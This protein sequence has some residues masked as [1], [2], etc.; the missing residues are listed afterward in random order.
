MLRDMLMFHDDPSLDPGDRVARA[1][2]FANAL[3]TADPSNDTAHYAVLREEAKQIERQSD[4]HLF[5]EQLEPWNE[6]VYFAEFMRRASGHGLAYVADSQSGVEPAA[7]AQLRESLGSDFDPIRMEQYLDFLR[8]RPFRRTILCHAAA[9]PTAEPVANEIRSLMIRGRVSPVDPSPDDAARGPGVIAFRT[10][11]D[12]KVTTNNPLVGAMLAVLMEA[13]PAVVSFDELHG[14]VAER[15]AGLDASVRAMSDEATLIAA[16]LACTKGGF[17]EFRTLPSPFA[18]RPGARPKASALARW[19]SLY[20]EDVTTLVHSE[21]SLAGMERFLIAHL[22][23]AKDRAQLARLT[24]HA[25]NAGELKLAGYVPTKE[26]LLEIVEDVLT[27]LGKSG[28][29]VA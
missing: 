9:R 1:R 24:E 2:A 7:M 12:V 21:Y 22:D 26:S 15:L 18:V 14:R 29:L 3:A 4:S 13:A 25:F 23:G 5:H 19:Q 16:L 11:D 6:P 20:T 10:P 8:G 28:L 27:R 17:V